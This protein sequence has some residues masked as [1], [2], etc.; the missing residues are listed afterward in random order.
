MSSTDKFAQVKDALTPRMAERNAGFWC[1]DG[2]LDLV[3][4][5]DARLLAANPNYKIAQIKEKF[6][7]LRYYIEGY[8]DETRAII[9]DAEERSYDI[10]QDCGST[11]GVG[12]VD[13]GA[14]ST[15]CEACVKSDHWFRRGYDL[16]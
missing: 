9:R 10:C 11:E 16:D 12:S 6:G 7:G 1:P 13:A 14:V 4:E 2:W 5:T 15:L 3:V 8:T